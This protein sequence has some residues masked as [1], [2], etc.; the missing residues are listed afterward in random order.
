MKE[1][2][3]DIFASL[4]ARRWSL[5]HV[6]FAVVAVLLAIAFFLALPYRLRALPGG[7]M[8]VRHVTE[9]TAVVNGQPQTITLPHTFRGLPPGTPISLTFAVD[10]RASFSLLVKTVYAPTEVAFNGET[11]SAYGKKG[12]YPSFLD[13]PPT[14]VR[15]FSFRPDVNGPRTG[16][17]T[18]TYEFPHDRAQLPVAPFSISNTSGLYRYEFGYLMACFFVEVFLALMGLV[19]VLLSFSIYDV[20]S[21]RGMLLFLGLFFLA[22]GVWNIGENDFSVFAIQNAV[23]LYLMAFTGLFFVIAPLYG[24]ALS[25]VTFRWQRLLTAVFYLEV[26]L[27]ALALLLQLAGLVMMMQSLFVFHLLHPLALALLVV[28]LVYEAV[29]EKNTRARWV[30]VPVAA[31]LA[32]AVLEILNYYVF[33]RFEFAMVFLFGTYVFLLLMLVLTGAIL[34]KDARMKQDYERQAHE[35][36]LL[37]LR[38]AA[39]KERH[40][41]MLAEERRLSGIRH[42]LKHHVS[43]LSELAQQ[44]NIERMKTYLAGL[45]KTIAARHPAHYA[46][47][48]AVNAIAAHYAAL[49]EQQGI[50]VTIDLVVPEHAGSLTDAELASVFGNLLENAIEACERSRGHVVPPPAAETPASEQGQ[51][52]FARSS[53]PSHELPPQP[54]LELKAR[55]L[56]GR[57]VIVLDNTCA[58]PP[59]KDGERYLSSKRG[60]RAPGLG[61]SSI[62]AIAAAHGGRATFDSD[63]RAFHSSVILEL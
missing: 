44:G 10:T 49:A 48:L 61:L 9:A 4:K 34:R 12:T 58:E 20:K 22:V 17:I 33:R 42:D 7:A 21:S 26:L 14:T 47:N 40:D 56:D 59:A 54:F 35:H 16:T 31:L 32:S 29:H 55:V 45:T 25:A 52:S 46:E 2:V 8:T 27:P 1:K 19:L 11:I 3:F 51:P 18:V 36:E 15:I 63:E 38:L 13:D 24:F 28:A 43:L 39:E 5:G 23:L 53:R 60:G 41:M 62:T 6:L 57:L 30:L 50:A 37:E